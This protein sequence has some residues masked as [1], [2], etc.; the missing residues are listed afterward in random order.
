MENRRALESVTIPLERWALPWQKHTDHVYRVT[1]RDAGRGSLDKDTSLLNV[2]AVWTTEPDTL[3]GVFTAD[4]V[5]LLVADPGIPLVACIHSGWKGTAQAITARTLQILKEEGG[6]DPSRAQAWFSP[7]ILPQSL[8]VGM[9]VIEAMEPLKDLGIEV[10][11]YWRPAGEKAYLDNQGL[12]AAMLEAA[13][14]RPEH[15][16]LS[17]LDTKTEDSCFSYRNE[18]TKT[19]EHFTFAWIEGKE[20]A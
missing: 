12:N 19:G 17:D 1:A 4:C 9:E 15:I 7:S 3:I 20:T 8:E 16:H 6:L 10:D 2:D 5:G 14:L 13:G 18:G 11:N